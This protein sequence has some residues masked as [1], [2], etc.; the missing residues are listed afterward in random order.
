MK[1]C[2]KCDN[3]YYIG[4][5]QTNNNNIQY[6]CRYCENI[7]ENISSEGSC[8]IDVNTKITQQND[9]VNEYTKQDP[10][11]PHLYNITCCNAECKSNKK[12][13]IKSDIIFLR[14]NDKDMKYVY[15]CTHC[16]HS[17]KTNDI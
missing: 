11:L 7:D 10:T 1:F 4:I 9:I 8:I 13:E 17:W 14:Y 3:M 15:I 2:N 16:D 12:A 6:Y 5:N